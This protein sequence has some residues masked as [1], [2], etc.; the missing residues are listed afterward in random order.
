[1]DDSS[2]RKEHLFIGGDWVDPDS[3]DVIEVISP[4]TEQV[5]GTVP[6]ATTVDVDRAVAAARSALT[7]GPWPA[8]SPAERADIMSALSGVLQARSTDIAQMITEQNG[9]PISWSIMGQVFSSTLALDYYADLTRTY[10]FEERRDGMMG[11]VLLR[12]EPVGVV[13][14]IVPWNVPLFTTML[15]LA[16]ALAAGCTVVLKPAPETPLDAYMLAEAAIEAGLPPGVL[17]IVAAGREVGEHLVTHPGVDKIAFTGSTAAGRRIAALCGEQLKRCTLELGGKS[18]AIICADAD[19]DA[20]VAGL[21]SASLMNNGQACVAQTRI[22]VQRD[23]YDDTVDALT[24]A[25]GNMVVGDPM[26]PATEI[27]PLTSAR[28]R[29]RVEGYI[30]AGRDEGA[31]VALGGGRPSGMD[32]GW[33]VEPTVF[34]GVDNSMR[35]AQEEI[36]GPVLAVMPYADESEAIAIANDSPYGLSGSVWSADNARATDI[37]RKIDT[38]TVSV[39]GFMIEFCSPFGGYKDSGLGRELGPEGLSHYLEMKSIM[40]LGGE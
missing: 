8:M 20:T 25:I 10:D 19:L 36:F 32:R 12:R 26:D 5:M 38:G 4:S 27:G 17:N 14:A 24:A 33:Y 37:A 40:L 35:I 16:P 28:Q 29:D 22:L 9:S 23:R 18:A 13:G 31:S 15:K 21:M 2:Y 1:V 7:S 34:T 6:D 3:S 39:N 11:P 30:S